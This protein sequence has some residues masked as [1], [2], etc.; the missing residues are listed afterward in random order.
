MIQMINDDQQNAQQHIHFIFIQLIDYSIQPTKK[1]REFP[2]SNDNNDAL[3]GS[4][5]LMM[6]ILIRPKQTKTTVSI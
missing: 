2:I 3:L 6:M 5:M 4:K 1:N